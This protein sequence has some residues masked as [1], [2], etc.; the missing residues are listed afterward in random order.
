MS[1]KTR[2]QDLENPARTNS[3]TDAVMVAAEA[4]DEDADADASDDAARVFFFSTK[5]KKH[6]KSFWK[7]MIVV[8][9]WFMFHKQKKANNYLI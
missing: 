5:S 9:Q 1:T 8:V 6:L 4:A 7:S 3:V 2:L